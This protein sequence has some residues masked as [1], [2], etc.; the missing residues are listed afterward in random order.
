MFV[1]PLGDSEVKFGVFF[2][3]KVT[4]QVRGPGCSEVPLESTV[5]GDQVVKSGGGL[6]GEKFFL[7]YIRPRGTVGGGDRWHWV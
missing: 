5:G 6:G 4:N 7:F 2:F 3:L 1:T